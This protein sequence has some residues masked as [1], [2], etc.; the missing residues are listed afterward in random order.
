MNLNIN[1]Y[2][3]ILLVVSAVI[4]FSGG[5]IAKNIYSDDDNKIIKA[6][7]IIKSVALL[8]IIGALLISIY[9]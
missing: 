4:G 6:K 5:A 2:S 7:I 9:L 3:I 1:I 8:G